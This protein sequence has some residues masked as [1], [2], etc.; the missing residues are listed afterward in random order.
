M[1]FVVLGG[2][3]IDPFHGTVLFLYSSKLM[4]SGIIQM[5][6]WFKIFEMCRDGRL[7]TFSYFIFFS[8][9]YQ[10]GKVLPL[11]NFAGIEVRRNSRISIFFV[12][13]VF[14]PLHLL[15]LL[16]IVAGNLLTFEY[17]CLLV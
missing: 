9:L 6:H 1:N 5:K 8:D 7:S 14:F 13:A 11:Q 2:V 12:S 17:G 4:F 15:L 3:V 16:V 10:Y